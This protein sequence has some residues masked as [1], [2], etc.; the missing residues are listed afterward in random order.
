MPSYHLHT[1]NDTEEI[2]TRKHVEQTVAEGA[3]TEKAHLI[4]KQENYLPSH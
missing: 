4:T 2:Y 1:S 3:F